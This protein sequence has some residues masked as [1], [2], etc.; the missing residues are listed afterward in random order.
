MTFPTFST[1][2]PAT[3]EEIETFAFET[4][5]ETERK[6][7]LAEKTFQSFRKLSAY[8][9]ADLFSNL[10]KALRKN[11]DRLAKVITAEMGKVSAEAEAEVEKCADEADWYAEHGPQMF[12]DTPATTGRVEAY[13][14]YL[15]LGPILA[16]MPWNFP[17]WQLTRMAIP[18]LLAG[19]VVLVKHSRNTQRSSLEFERVMLEAGFPEGAFQN[20]ILKTED[21]VNVINDD[22]VHGASVTG[23]VRA[24]SAVASEAGKVIKSTIMELG[25]SDAFVVC[26]DADIP[27]AVAAGIS[28]RFGNAGQVCLAA[29]RFI[30]MDEIADEFEHRFVEAAK[31]IQIG[32]PTNPSTKMGPMARADLRD[33]LHKQVEGTVAMGARVLCGGTRPEGKGAYYTPTVLTG[34]TDAMPAFKEETFGPVAA[35]ARVRDIEEAVKLANA[36]D[37]GLSGNIWT[38]DIALARKVARDWYTGGVFI[39]GYTRT[40]PRVPVGGVKNSG[41][42]RELSHFGAHA[43]VNVQTVWIEPH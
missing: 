15:P 12:A 32:D 37:F 27:K 18:T 26:K 9:R 20:L 11:K 24:G 33:E 39:N 30:L 4:A 40:N 14:S 41:Y 2:N 42:G 31:S 25:G 6:L 16:I 36:S 34:V 23:S 3:G 5:S 28:S 38:K 10:A 17:L 22:R 29:K 7:K 13:V 35:I 8:Q 21:V 19:N 1:V 43:F